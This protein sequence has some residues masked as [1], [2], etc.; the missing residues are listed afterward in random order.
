MDAYN[1][2]ME[3]VETQET[4]AAKDLIAD[5]KSVKSELLVSDDGHRR[6][7]GKISTAGSEGVIGLKAKQESDG[8]KLCKFLEIDAYSKF[9]QMKKEFEN[10]DKE[11]FTKYELLNGL[12]KAYDS[13]LMSF[14][15]LE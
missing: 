10:M 2:Q 7:D 1:K 12:T 4:R 11:H 9:M 13:V 3:I 6:S 14:N 5:N 15:L 8:D